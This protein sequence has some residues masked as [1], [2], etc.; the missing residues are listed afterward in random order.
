MSS[1]VLWLAAAYLVPRILL[2]LELDRAG[3]T[4]LDCT[5]DGLRWPHNGTIVCDLQF[6][7]CNI[8]AMLPIII[9][10][11]CAYG[12]IL[13]WTN[14]EKFKFVKSHPTENDNPCL[15]LQ[16]FPW[17]DSNSFETNFIEDIAHLKID[18]LLR[19]R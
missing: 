13:P 9:K 11:P 12:I 18:L 15:V 14:I 2:V 4:F 5:F 17:Q 16:A 7:R 3:L 19:Y 1:N 6:R 8:R 10:R